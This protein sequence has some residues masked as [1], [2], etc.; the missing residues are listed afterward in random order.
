MFTSCIGLSYEGKTFQCKLSSVCKAD[1]PRPEP[2][3]L[4]SLR[5]VEIVDSL[6]DNTP[7][8]KRHSSNCG[9]GYA[10]G[11]GDALDLASSVRRVVFTEDGQGSD[12]GSRTLRIV[13]LG[14]DVPCC[15]P[16][17]DPARS[18]DWIARLTEDLGRVDQLQQLSSSNELVA[19]E[20]A[21]RI[22]QAQQDIHRIA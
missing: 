17:S 19:R 13:E 21:V 22:L 6:R 8:G 14:H 7:V 2:D 3:A 15:A 4:R 10:R 5:P 11:N 20:T 1:A 9:L 16:L 12:D 18:L